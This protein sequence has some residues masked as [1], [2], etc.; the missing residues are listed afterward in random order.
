MIPV[1]LRPEMKT[2]LHAAHM[3]YDGSRT[4]NDFLAKDVERSEANG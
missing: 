3:V 1:S 4:R 2:R